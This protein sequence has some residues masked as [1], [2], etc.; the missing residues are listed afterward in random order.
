MC[1]YPIDTINLS[2]CPNKRNGFQRVLLQLID[3]IEAA[4]FAF[5]KLTAIPTLA[6]ARAIKCRKKRQMPKVQHRECRRSHHR[7]ASQ[8]GAP[9][10][11]SAGLDRPVDLAFQLR[12]CDFFCDEKAIPSRT[13]W[14]QQNKSIYDNN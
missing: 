13:A 2:G 6:R 12:F 9:V 5:A 8:S 10:L 1:K 3:G 14:E 4:D 11:N 7:Y